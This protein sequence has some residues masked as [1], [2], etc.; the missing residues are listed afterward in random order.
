MYKICSTPNAVPWRGCKVS[1]NKKM[2][3]YI[4]L[5]L[6]KV[7]TF[8]G[9]NSQISSKEHVEKPAQKKNLKWHTLLFLYCFFIKPWNF[10]ADV[11]SESFPNYHMPGCSKSFILT[12]RCI[13]S[14]PQNTKLGFD[15]FKTKIGEH[16]HHSEAPTTNIFP[17]ILAKKQH[18]SKENSLY[19]RQGCRIVFSAWK[20][21]FCA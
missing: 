19:S 4:F 18:F 1:Q 12:G 16:Y 7:R 10:V 9:T 6:S 3:T 13:A 14:T 5:F 11:E 20:P 15:N 21:I 8:P 2:H 17:R